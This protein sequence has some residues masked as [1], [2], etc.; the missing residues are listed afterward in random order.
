M[1]GH[2]PRERGQ[3]DE[4]KLGMITHQRT[5]GVK[6]CPERARDSMFRLAARTPLRLTAAGSRGQ[7]CRIKIDGTEQ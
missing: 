1:V 5:Q 3:W 6:D 2:N 4:P 7:P